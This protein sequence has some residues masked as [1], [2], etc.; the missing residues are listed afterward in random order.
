MNGTRAATCP[1]VSVVIPCFNQAHYLPEAIESVLS[2]SYPLVEIIVVD[3]GSIDDTAKVAASYPEVRLF[4]QSNQGLS[5]AR[6]RGLRESRGDLL[7]FLDADDRLLPG[8]L[9]AG[10]ACLH[11]HPECA[12]AYGQYQFIN[13]DGTLNKRIERAPASGD[14]YADFLRENR[15][16]MHAAV[17]Y[18]RWV[19]E[20]VGGFN[21]R[22]KACEDYEMYFRIVRRF[23][24]VEHPALVAEYRRHPGSMSNHAR[25]MLESA[26]TVLD[27][28]AVHIEDDP[29]LQAAL[30][31]GR[32]RVAG[33]Y[34]FRLVR[35]LLPPN[36]DRRNW[37]RGLADLWLLRKHPGGFIHLR[38]WLPSI[39]DSR[40]TGRSEYASA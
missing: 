2:Q 9:S 29:D 26:L 37:R 5:A 30:Q 14:T 32:R 34:T 6:N 21:K 33:Y 4:R 38:L 39:V 35:S 20:R 7:V 15:V 13:E 36:I 17:M 19:F 3:D 11:E 12:F 23:P 18:R 40:N 31:E 8:G 22:L 27:G 24:V 25:K 28:E 16:A 1:L 10:V